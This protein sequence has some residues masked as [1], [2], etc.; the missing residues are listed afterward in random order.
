MA[1]A[2]WAI[3]SGVRPAQPC[4][5]SPPAFDTADTSAGLVPLPMPPSTT[6]C[7]TPNRSHTR[8]CSIGFR[9]RAARIGHVLAST[10]VL[11]LRQLLRA[12]SAYAGRFDASGKHLYFVSDLSG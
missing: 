8:V 10:P 7:E 3:S 6:G 4:T 2:S 12:R 1:S 5:P 11:D 9:V